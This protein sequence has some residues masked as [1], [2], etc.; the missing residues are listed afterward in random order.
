V[1]KGFNVKMANSS[2]ERVSNVGEFRRE[3]IA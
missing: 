2:D 1:F 3:S